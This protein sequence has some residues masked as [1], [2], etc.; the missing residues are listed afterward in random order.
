MPDSPPK[1]VPIRDAPQ[2]SWA[3]REDSATL[4]MNFYQVHIGDKDIAGYDALARVG[5]WVF[6]KGL[7]GQLPNVIQ[8][9]KIARAFNPADTTGASK[10]KANADLDAAMTA[11]G[12]TP[13]KLGHSQWVML[14]H[15]LYSQEDVR[16]IAPTDVGNGAAW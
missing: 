9:N 3:W 4:G 10:D 13:S 5:H 15:V 12:A 6:T 8:L 14:H 7:G 2:D 16:L 11:S 1:P